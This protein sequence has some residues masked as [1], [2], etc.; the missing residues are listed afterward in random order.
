MAYDPAYAVDMGRGRVKIGDTV[1]AQ[2]SDGEWYVG[3][4]VGCGGIFA[5]VRVPGRY[6]TLVTGTGQVKELDPITALGLLAEPAPWYARLWH[7]LCVK[8]DRMRW[9]MLELMAHFNK[10]SH[11]R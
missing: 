10:H 1:M 5:M 7:W 4:L 2:D 6:G 9:P 11:G 3:T 8:R